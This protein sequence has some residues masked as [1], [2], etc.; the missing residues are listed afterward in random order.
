MDY[1]LCSVGRLCCVSIYLSPTTAPAPLHSLFLPQHQLHCT[2]LLPQ[3]QL[4]Y[5]HFSY[6]ST[7]STTLISPTTAPAPLHSSPTT[8]PAPLHSSPTTAPAPL[9]KTRNYSFYWKNQFE[10]PNFE[11]LS[12]SLHI[13]SEEDNP[14]TPGQR[15]REVNTNNS[16]SMQL[17]VVLVQPVDDPINKSFLS[18][19]IK[20]AEALAASSFG[21]WGIGKITKNLGRNLLVTMDRHYED[22]SELLNITE[23]GPWKVKCRLPASQSTSVEIIE[24][25]GEDTSN[26]DLTEALKEA[27]FK[28]AVAERIFKG[29]QKIKTTFKVIFNSNSLSPYVKIGYQQYRVNTYIGKPWQCYKC[30]RFGHSAGFCR[31]APRCVVCSGPHTSNEFNKTTGRKSC[32]CGGHTANFGGCP[33]MKQAKEMEKTRQIQ[34][35]SY[36]DA[37]KQVLKQ[38]ATPTSQPQSVLSTNTTLARHQQDSGNLQIPK[39]PKTKTVGTQTIDELQT[40]AQKHVTINQLL[41]LLIRVFTAASQKDVQMDVPE[42][43]HKIA[44]ETFQLQS[45]HASSENSQQPLDQS[46]CSSIIFLQTIEEISRILPPMDI[47]PSPVIGRTNPHKKNQAQY[48]DSD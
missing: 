42:M 6:H 31:S 35:L 15:P 37:V 3:H 24:P 38:T 25:F 23:I 48:W 21:N 2:L 26:E 17:T 43:V 4:H 7:S 45:L 10:I 29:K 39:T 33:K 44:A 11:G 19:E 46:Q 14:I 1:N 5:T 16:I 27:G 9:Q 41:D 18:N 32:N 30:Q 40:P 36:R 8:A 20:L 12:E 28:G 13:S 22:P 34:K 47:T